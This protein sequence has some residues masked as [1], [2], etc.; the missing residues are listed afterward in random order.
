[1][2]KIRYIFIYVYAF[3]LIGCSGESKKKPNIIILF[4]D[5]LGWADLGYK[6]QKF[7]TPHIDALH[8]EGVYFDNA[9]IS[10][11]TCSPSR[12][13]ILTGKHAVDL[14]LFRHVPST[15]TTKG[16]SWDGEPSKPYHVWAGD[17][18]QMPSKNWLD[19]E[20]TTYA[21]SLK[22]QGYYNAFFGKWHLGEKEHY[23][24]HQGF[25]EQHFVTPWGAPTRYYPPYFVRWEDH[26]FPGDST[27]TYL[28]D[29]ITNEVR[30]FVQN[31]DKEQPFQLSLFY[32]NVHHPHQ[33]KIEW[34]RRYRKMG[35]S[36]HMAQYAAMVT[37]LD[38]S[39]GEIIQALK[40]KQIIDN[41]LIVFSS[42]QGGYF[43]NVPFSGGKMKNTLYEGGTRVPLIIKY[44]NRYTPKIVQTPVSTFD[45]LPTLV[46][47]AGCKTDLINDID[48]KSLMPLIENYAHEFESRYLIS[49]R[50]Y[51]NQYI[52]LLDGE[53]KFVGYRD[54]TI[55]LFDLE[56]DIKETTDLSDEHPGKIEKYIDFIRNWEKQKGVLAFSGFKNETK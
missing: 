20:E 2:K 13:S 4:A 27:K 53:W 33:G 35:F 14:E 46:D 51:E 38:E 39:V 9:R 50:S 11:P 16:F 12:G 29:S 10:V 17:P 41:T 7:I 28:T 5:D 36:E 1:M 31:Y 23:P 52:S 22:A 8:A 47:V 34:V 55:E 3:F 43:E 25:D 15:D 45:I 48:G 26:P 49:Y 18:V 24:I 54:G 6:Q 30:R 19:T 42:D 44:G 56:K 32:Y 37:A 40:D 21:E